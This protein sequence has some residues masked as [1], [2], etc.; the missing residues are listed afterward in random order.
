VLSLAK[1][2]WKSDYRMR[3]L[4]LLLLLLAPI[5]CGWAGAQSFD[6]SSGRVQ[7]ASLDGLWRFHTGDNPAWA[8][9]KFDDSQ[10]AL[11]RSDQDWAQQGYQGYSGLAWYRFQVA[12]PAALDRVS[13]YLPEIDTCYEVLADGK[14]IGRYGRMPPNTAPYAGGGR[15]LVYPLPAGNHRDRKIE[16]AVRVWHWPGWAKYYGGGPQNGGGRVGESAEIDEIGAQS[17]ARLHWRLTSYQTL[18]LLQTLAGLGT[19]ALFALRRKEKEYLYFG[20]AMLASAAGGWVDVSYAVQVWNVYLRDIVSAVADACAGLALILFY[21]AL[22]KPRRTLL[23]K[24]AIASVAVEPLVTAL[25]IV[26]GSTLDIWLDALLGALLQL[27]FYGWVIFAVAAAARRN[28][29]DARLLVAPVV[30]SASVNLFENAAWVTYT[31]DWQHVFDLRV[32]LMREPF[33]IDL[34]QAAGALFLL[35]VSGILILRFARTRSEEERYASE[36][37]AARGVQQYLIPDHLP[38]TP[39]LAIESEYRPAREVGGD[40]FQVLADGKDESAL[41]V[42]GDVAGHGLEAGML[43]TLLVGAIRTAAAFTCDPAK[44]VEQLN[45]RLQGRGLAT[46]LALRIERDGSAVLVNAGHLAPYL[47]GREMALEGAL[48]LGARPESEFPLVRFNLGPQDRL[49]LVTDGIAEAQDAQGR[50]F[51][52]ER[53]AEMLRKGAAGAGLAEAAQAFGQEDDITVLTVA[54]VAAA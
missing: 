31:L 33:T 2:A 11:L 1:I 38:H 49:M 32:K 54:R 14:L 37:Q 25:R 43:A 53:I 36:L 12:V 46:C 51:G 22:L 27:V 50:L 30:L 45:E 19:L 42:L 52:F 26:T 5:V 35:A 16:V 17:W 48:P 18:A 9:P 34:A 20:L 40:F 39:G 8:D 7:V 21:L 24:I 23:L 13:L 4:P 41:I 28:S 47:N 10:W 3:K 15:F 44:I 6:L 29:I